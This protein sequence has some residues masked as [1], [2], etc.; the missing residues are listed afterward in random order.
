MSLTLLQSLK[1]YPFFWNKSVVIG[2]SSSNGLAMVMWLSMYVGLCKC[3][4]EYICVCICVCIRVC[5]CVC[6]C[7]YVLSVWVR[8]YVCRRRI[9]SLSWTPCSHVRDESATDC[10]PQNPLGPRNPSHSLAISVHFHSNRWTMTCLPSQ[11]GSR[12][13]PLASTVDKVRA[14][15]CAS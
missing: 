13:S 11:W 10:T 4:C 1:S 2:H 7:V 6:V 3:I 9:F 8:V 5:I 15:D 14:A 12:Y